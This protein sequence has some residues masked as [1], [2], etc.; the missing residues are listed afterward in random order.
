[1]IFIKKGIAEFFGY[2]FFIEK[3]Q[4]LIGFETTN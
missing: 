4:W 2:V 3:I 1:M